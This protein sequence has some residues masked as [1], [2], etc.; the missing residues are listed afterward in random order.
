[1]P[2]IYGVNP[3]REFLKETPEKVIE[4]I[5]AQGRGG[6]GVEEIYRLATAVGIPILIRKRADL[7]EMTGEGV[8][9]GVI[10]R[11]KEFSYATLDEV[12][13]NRH[14]L[15]DGD[16]VV[17]A[18]EVSDPHNLG[19][20]IRTAHCLGANGVVIPARRAASVTAS[21]VKASA[22]AVKYLPIARET[23]I[24]YVIEELKR[25]GYWV[26]AAES[27]AQEN[28]E[29]L[30]LVG[31]IAVILGGE[32][33]GIRRLVREKAD[34]LFAIPMVGRIDSLNVSVAAGIVLYKIFP[35]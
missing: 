8:H 5:V 30:T 14:P 12:M 34:F 32:G 13:A 20:I 1:M 3:L 28:L 9:Q 21:V 23:N 24:V 17:I 2:I 29:S 15:L 31:S 25:H 19:A 18:D 11:I 35:P 10:G 33:Q 4:V 22:G 6:R 26:Y 16:I 7:D 27:R